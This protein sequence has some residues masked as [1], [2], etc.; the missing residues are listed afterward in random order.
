MAIFLG[1]DGAREMKTS[2][3]ELVRRAGGGL[4]TPPAHFSGKFISFMLRDEGK[5]R[6]A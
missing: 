3:G 2:T 1:K 5:D 6:L 4:E